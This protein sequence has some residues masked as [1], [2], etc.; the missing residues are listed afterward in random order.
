MTNDIYPS[1]RFQVPIQP[2]A[3][4]ETVQERGAV[5]AMFAGDL[6]A[7]GDVVAGLAPA[8]IGGGI[9][10]MIGAVAAFTFLRQ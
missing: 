3:R 8:Y 4:V 10:E 1:R 6:G 5:F 9:G 2:R 7:G